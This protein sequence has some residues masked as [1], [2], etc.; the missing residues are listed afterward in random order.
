[1]NLSM[2]NPQEKRVAPRVEASGQTTIRLKGVNIPAELADV[3]P[4]G[5]KLRVRPEIMQ[6]VEKVLPVEV[7]LEFP[8]LQIDASVMWSGAGLLGCQ[9]ARQLSLGEVGAVM[10]TKHRLR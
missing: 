8:G 7:S 10:A 2:G 4:G 3:S 6:I 1:M 9:F 5:C